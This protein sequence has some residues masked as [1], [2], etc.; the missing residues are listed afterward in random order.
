MAG[1][2]NI[3][4]YKVLTLNFIKI[5]DLDRE[6]T[7]PWACNIEV[8]YVCRNNSKFEK[9]N[10]V[11]FTVYVYFQKQIVDHLMVPIVDT[12]SSNPFLPINPLE[13]EPLPIPWIVGTVTFE[14]FPKSAGKY[15]IIIKL[16][17]TVYEIFWM[18]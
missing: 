5:Q 16:E 9:I 8:N 12:N 2:A 15:L 7:L 10:W 6:S 4:Y 11:N 3:F 17:G 1:V 18:K 14:G 13:T